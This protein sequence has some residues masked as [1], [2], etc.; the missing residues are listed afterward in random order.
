MNNIKDLVENKHPIYK[1]YY[2]Y[3]NFLLE[4]YEGGVD[5]TL[6]Y[7]N[8]SNNRFGALVDSLFK[9]FAGN[10]EMVNVSRSNLFQHPKE[11]SQDYKE[12]V[13][14][15]YFYNFCSPIIDIYTDHLF[16]QSILEDFGSIKNIVDI[17]RDNVDR[18]GSSIGEFRKE[19]SESCQIYGHSFV[20]CD[21]PSVDKP[22]LTFKDVIDNDIFPYFTI[23]PPQN[24]INWALDGFGKPYWVV[25]LE[26]EDA[27]SDPFN[28]N[29]DK[30]MNVYYRLWTRQ[31]WILYDGEYNEKA[32][33]VHGLGFVPITCVFDKA[34]KKVRNFLGVSSL[35]DI[36]FISRDIY[37][38]CSELKQILRDQ[39]FSFLAIQGT[40]SEYDE[41]SVGTGKGLLYPKDTN[42]PEY[43]SPPS[44]NAEVYFNH[45]DRQITKIYQLAKLEGGSVQSSGQDATPQSGTSKAWDF[46]QTNSA[47]AK[48]AGNME[49]GETKLWQQFAAWQGKE[50][51]GSIAYPNEFSIQ[52]L[53]ADLDEAEQIARLSMG[54]TFNIEVKKAIIRKKFPRMD[55]KLVTKVSKEIEE[56]EGKGEGGRLLDRIP[57]LA[58]RLAAKNNNANSGGKKEDVN[59]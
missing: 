15:S 38:S 20:L 47:L 41:L 59:V 22:I 9:I 36:A 44:A 54:K 29:K 51:D 4:S 17:R 56:N 23:F 34:S 1:K 7:V 11:R 52:S 57:S 3:F 2:D 26:S 13:Q 25:V 16:K 45:I 46:N 18:K 19:L 5:Y 6:A 37:N 8:S 33:G 30:M 49:D 21:T 43:V 58:E 55:E 10:T 40:A 50:F 12:R 24:I 39:T 31:E 32:R 14:M 28:T 42:K 48:K 27:N 53:K 35:A